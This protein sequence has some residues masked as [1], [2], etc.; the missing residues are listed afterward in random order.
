[1]QMII[2]L[3]DDETRTFIERITAMLI[4]AEVATVDT[5]YMTAVVEVLGVRHFRNFLQQDPFAVV[6]IGETTLVRDYDMDNSATEH[7]MIFS[8]ETWSSENPYPLIYKS[9][10]KPIHV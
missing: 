7:V 4:N 10:E 3:N 8:R 5:I 1:M 6:V 9:K 2:S